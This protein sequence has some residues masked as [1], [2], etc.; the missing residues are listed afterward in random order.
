MYQGVSQGM[1]PG[2]EIH[3]EKPFKQKHLAGV[4]LVEKMI[5]H[6]N[7]LTL[8]PNFFVVLSLKVRPR[9]PRG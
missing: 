8:S 6:G 4:F 2:G 7:P 1:N 5:K 9:V 3:A